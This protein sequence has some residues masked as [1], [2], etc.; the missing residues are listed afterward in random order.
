[1]KIKDW[2]HYY[3]YEIVMLVFCIVVLLIVFSGLLLWRL[4]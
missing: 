3:K 4:A 1:M 2:I